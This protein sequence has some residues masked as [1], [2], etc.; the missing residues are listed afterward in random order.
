MTIVALLLVMQIVAA[1]LVYNFNGALDAAEQHGFD[2]KTYTHAES[3]A[4]NYL[5]LEVQ[6]AFTA[7]G[8]SCGATCTT[9]NAKVRSLKDVSPCQRHV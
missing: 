9:D 8:C 5:R 4:T 1:A 2:I 7:G 6:R 3:K